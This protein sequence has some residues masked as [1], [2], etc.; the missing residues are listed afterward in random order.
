MAAVILEKAIF[1]HVPKTGGTWV[2]KSLVRQESCVAAI[3]G[4]PYFNGP[5]PCDERLQAAYREQFCFAFVRHPL[6]WWQSYWCHRVQKNWKNTSPDFN[7]FI[8]DAC[9]KNPGECGQVFD[10]FL[11]HHKIDFIGRFERLRLDLK[12][13]LVLSSTEFNQDLFVD[14]AINTARKTKQPYTA[15]T[16]ALVRKTEAKTMKKFGYS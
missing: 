15:K 3:K 6:T 7:E 2:T 10:K 13:A 12:K 8:K 11:N 5:R 4:H 1:L 14:H 9:L 16:E